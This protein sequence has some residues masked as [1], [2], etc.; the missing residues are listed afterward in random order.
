MDTLPE[1]KY[2]VALSF[3][4]QDEAL[5]RQLNDLL[6]ERLNTFAYFDRQEEIGGTDG[7]VTFNRVF[8]QEARIVAVLHR[9]NWGTTPWT[10][11]EETAIRNRGYDQGYDFVIMIP[12]DDKPFMPKWLPKTSIWIGLN[13][14]GLTSAAAVIEARVQEAGGTLRNESPVQQ[15]SRISR[16]KAN[17][18]LRLALINSE[19]GVKRANAELNTLF[20]EMEKTTAEINAIGGNI[21]IA[22]K[23][24]DERTINLHSWG[25]HVYISWTYPFSNSLDESA[26]EIRT[27]KR[28]PFP[29]RDSTPTIL[30]TDEFDADARLPDQF[31]WTHKREKRFFTSKLLADHCLKLL[32]TRLQKDQPWTRQIGN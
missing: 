25:Y 12:V 31:G 13:R 27:L 17:N 6:S 23:R 10:R 9:A 2:D 14:W 21:E 29:Y 28:E 15:A 20:A 19:G 16:Q 8:G 18:E 7:E 26:L 5:A 11:I 22:C 32:L 30:A 1:F 24:I 3:L 4:Q